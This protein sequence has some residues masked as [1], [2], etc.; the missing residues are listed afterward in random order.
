VHSDDDDYVICRRRRW[1]W[2]RRISVKD[3]GVMFDDP[4]RYENES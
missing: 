4:D 3:C 2:R 1:W